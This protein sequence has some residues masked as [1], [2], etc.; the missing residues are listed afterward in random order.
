VKKL[1]VSTDVTY[2]TVVGIDAETP[3]ETTTF[4]NQILIRPSAPS[5]VFATD[6]DSGSVVLDRTSNAVVGLLWGQNI[7]SSGVTYWFASHIAPVLD[8][9]KCT[10]R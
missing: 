6:G 7:D 8:R 1:G 3:V 5:T 9:F 2:G 4:H 10:I